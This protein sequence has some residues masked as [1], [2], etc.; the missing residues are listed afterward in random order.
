MKI[1]QYQKL[2]LSSPLK[3]LTKLFWTSIC[4]ILLISISILAVPLFPNS[5]YYWFVASAIILLFIFAEIKYYRPLSKEIMGLFHE[6]ESSEKITEILKYSPDDNYIYIKNYS[7]S[8]IKTGNAN[9]LI[10]GPKG[11]IIL[12]IRNYSGDF[13]VLDNGD[14]VRKSKGIYKLYWKNPFEKIIETKERFAGF[15][16][17]KGIDIPITP[18][19]VLAEGKI[20]TAGSEIK[21]YITD[22]ENLP[23]Y[24][25]KIPAVSNFSPELTS[26]IIKTLGISYNN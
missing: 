8:E 22:A 12:D 19:I 10:I 16:R 25:S 1:V 7:F 11:I 9:G 5:R 18:L 6:K 13:R 2:K 26:R 21:S 20:D 23:I 4:L 14:L 17:K 3:K 15:L 24:I